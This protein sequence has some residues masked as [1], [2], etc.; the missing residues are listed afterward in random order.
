MPKKNSEHVSQLS[1]IIGE[2]MGF[3]SQVVKEIEMPG[4]LYD[5]GKIAVREDVLNK[6][7][8]LTLSEYNEIIKHPENG[9]QILKSVDKFFSIVDAY[10]A[11]VS[12]RAYRKVKSHDYAISELKRCSGTQF[13]SDIVKVFLTFFEEEN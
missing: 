5:I 3:S 12:Y 10:E 13:D 11:M 4:L 8:K 2:K 1:K 7:E 9:Y 6:P